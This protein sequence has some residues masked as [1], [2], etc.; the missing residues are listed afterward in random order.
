MSRLLF[1]PS[2][3][4]DLLEIDY[5]KPYDTNSVHDE[6]RQLRAPISAAI[7]RERI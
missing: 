4:N 7:A 3:R 5:H 6:A 1:S 2:A